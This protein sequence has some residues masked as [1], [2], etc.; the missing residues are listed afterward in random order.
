MKN[1]MSERP[2]TVY[3]VAWHWI[4]ALALVLAGANASAQALRIVAANASNSAVYEVNFAG[5]GGSITPLNNDQSVHVSFRSLVFVANELT[6]KVDLLV[7][8]TSRGEIVRYADASGAASSIWR[9][10]SGSG[11]ANPDGLSIDAGGNLYVVSSAPGS[12]K[13]AELWVLPRDSAVPKGSGFLAPR[14]VDNSF[15]GVS[16]QTLEETV[17]ARTSSAAAAAGDLLVLSGDPATVFVYSAAGL[18]SVID[19]AGAISPNRVLISSTQ[20]PAGVSPGG[21]DF[22]PIDNSLL[23]TTA[24]GTVL[25]YSFT[26]NDA[27]RAPDFTTQL[28]NGKFK[29]RTG[30]EAAVPYAFVANNNGGNILKFGAPPPQGGSNPPLAIVTS[31]VQRPQ[32][33]AASNLAATDASTCLESAGGCDILGNVIKH[34]VRGV[35]SLSGYVIEEPCVVQVDP[36]IAQYGTC[37]GH[38]LAVSQVCAGYGDTVIPDYMCGGSGPSGSGFAL[39]K[40]VSDTLDSTKGVL[41]LN[42][43]FTENVLNGSSADCPQ[44]VLGWAPT[45]EEGSIVEGNAMLELTGGCGSSIA[46]S[47]GLSLWGLGLILN[48]AALPGKNITDKRINFALTKYNSLDSTILAASIA[49]PFKTALVACLSTSRGF[50]QKK[51]YTNAAGQLLTCD[52]LVAN[53]EASFSSTLSNP[54]PSGDVRGRLANLYL[55]INTRILG[56]DALGTWPPLP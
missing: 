17:F 4:M 56:N 43:A 32:G 55:T 21:M 39:I 53:N 30:L 26:T 7:A 44:E 6:G 16:V 54:N 50:F 20:F 42:E 52:S 9:S 35:Q 40:S 27:S 13:P 49:S 1:I 51:K 15:G 19:G 41:I 47:R 29:I 10:S 37:T 48:E 28:G 24:A 31:G 36:R 5:G 22:W 33:I 18:K 11:P 12:P 34:D 25:R 45:V 38:T 46:S 23:V 2:S 14:L 3:S 8:D